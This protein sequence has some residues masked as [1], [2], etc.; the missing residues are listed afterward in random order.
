MRGTDA[1]SGALFSYVDLEARV[2]RDHP[3]RVI[4]VLVNEALVALAGDFAAL[5][6]GMGRA[7]IPP[8][9]L[10][11]AMLLQAFY[12]IR[13]ERPLMERLEFGLL[14]RWPHPEPVEGCGNRRGR[15]GVGPFDLF[16]E[17]RPASGRRHRGEVPWRGAGAAPGEAAFVI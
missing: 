16:Q 17:P 9:K 5:Y 15:C 1:R 10:L 13:S 12:S 7:L 2:R 3:L 8:E 14:F 6:S 11:R 4:R